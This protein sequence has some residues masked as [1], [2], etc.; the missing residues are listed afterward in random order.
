MNNNDHLYPY[1]DGVGGLKMVDG[2][3]R[4]D[5]VVITEIEGD[6][7]KAQRVSGLAMSL[8]ASIKLKDQLTSMIDDLKQ[9]GVLQQDSAQH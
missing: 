7:M 9:K 2:V 3:V 8:Q 5:L 6:Q 4:M 1:V